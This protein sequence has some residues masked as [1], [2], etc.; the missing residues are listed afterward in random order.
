MKLY[1]E[2]QIREALWKTEHPFSDGKNVDEIMKSLI[3]IELPSDEDA[4]VTALKIVETLKDKH[5]AEQ[6][7]F[8]LAGFQTCVKWLKEQIL[9]QNK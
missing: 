7:A 2:E 9:N 4:G 5:T 8:Y 3:P 6:E 1:T